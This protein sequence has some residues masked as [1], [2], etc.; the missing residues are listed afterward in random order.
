MKNIVVI[1]SLI[2]L[3]CSNVDKTSKIESDIDKMGWNNLKREQYL[4][5]RNA[6]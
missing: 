2:I 6:W 4:N 5:N 1:L 3:G